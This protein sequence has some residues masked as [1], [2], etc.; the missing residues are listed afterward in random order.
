M[1]CKLGLKFNHDLIPICREPC[2]IGLL[3]ICMLMPQ[4]PEKSYFSRRA[5][6]S[7]QIKYGR[8]TGSV[9]RP[10]QGW[11]IHL[12]IPPGLRRRDGILADAIKVISVIIQ[13]TC[14]MHKA[15]C[16]GPRRN[17]QSDR[18]HLRDPHLNQGR[19]WRQL[20]ED[21]AL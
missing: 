17:M 20:V 18:L 2:P 7:E 19:W 14:G 3:P 15:K 12:G 9:L 16:I 21:P 8:G 13:N 10:G 5:N 4:L 11:S 1:P 6:W